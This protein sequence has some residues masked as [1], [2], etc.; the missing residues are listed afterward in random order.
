MLLAMIL[1]RV[2]TEA[3]P[4]AVVFEASDAAGALKLLCEDTLAEVPEICATAAA[5]TGAFFIVDFI[6]TYKA[7]SD[8]VKHDN[9]ICDVVKDDF[10]QIVDDFNEISV[11]VAK[12]KGMIDEKRYTDLR[13]EA[14]NVLDIGRLFV[15]TAADAISNLDHFTGISGTSQAVPLTVLSVFSSFVMWQQGAVDTEKVL[16]LAGITTAMCLQGCGPEEECRNPHGIRD[17]FMTCKNEMSKGLAF[18]VDLRDCMDQQGHPVCSAQEMTSQTKN[19][20]ATFLN[21]KTALRDLANLLGLPSPRWEESQMIE[22]RDDLAMP[23]H[24]VFTYVA[25]GNKSLPVNHSTVLKSFRDYFLNFAFDVAS[26][27]DMPKENAAH[28]DAVTRDFSN[29]SCNNFFKFTQWPV[30]AA[31]MVAITCLSFIAWGLLR[32]LVDDDDS[33]QALEKKDNND[34]DRKDKR[35]KALENSGVHVMWWRVLKQ[36][37]PFLLFVDDDDDAYQALEEKDDNDADREEKREKA[38]ENNGVDIMCWRSAKQFSPFLACFL[39]FAALLYFGMSSFHDYCNAH[40]NDFHD[41]QSLGWSATKLAA[42][43]DAQYKCM[44]ICDNEESVSLQAELRDI[45]MDSFLHQQMLTKH[46][47]E[48]SKITQQAESCDQDHGCSTEKHFRIQTELL[49][50]VKL[51]FDQFKRDERVS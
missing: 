3:S 43:L 12:W 39:L 37:S 42:N 11:R 29:S 38:L 27:H 26:H 35:K 15:E 9:S 7:Y 32:W 17:H 28:A 4:R 36:F 44:P 31:L 45:T 20:Q 2:A 5:V 41:D 48:I 34:A 21:V 50:A 24:A 18:V 25:A 6:V 8:E 40:A 49:T 16:V 51:V 30:V 33:Y 10:Q 1:P 14:Q 22:H 19:M 13:I 46:I 23:L 47:P